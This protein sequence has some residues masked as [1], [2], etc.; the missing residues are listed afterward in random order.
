MPTFE[1]KQK[2]QDVIKAAHKLAKPSAEKEEVQDEKNRAMLKFVGYEQGAT[3]LKPKA[4]GEF[5]NRAYTLSYI[6]RAGQ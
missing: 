3:Q 5:Y 1:D 4:G 6:P 2:K